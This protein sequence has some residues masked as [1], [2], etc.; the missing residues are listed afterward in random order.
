MPDVRICSHPSYLTLL[1]QSEKFNPEEVQSL[2]GLA[3]IAFLHSEMDAD[4][5][6]REA[7]TARPSSSRQGLSAGGAPGP[8]R[9]SGRG[10][11]QGEF[12]SG[13]GWRGRRG[14]TRSN[15]GPYSRGGGRRDYTDSQQNAA[16]YMAFC[17]FSFS[18]IP[19]SE[20]RVGGR[21][22]LFAQQWRT[23]TSDEWVL[24]GIRCG[25]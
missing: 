19:T 23:V 14:A 3:F 25:F 9:P 1:K 4:K 17:P 7:S 12:R 2:F 8:I 15:G 24:E 22:T 6:A 21:A 18:K 10:Y 11:S 13:S 20:I 5:R 16:R